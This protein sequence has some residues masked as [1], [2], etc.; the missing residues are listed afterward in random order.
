MRAL[1][2]ALGLVLACPVGVSAQVPVRTFGTA[3]RTGAATPVTVDAHGHA[4]V[5]IA[6]SGNTDAF[7]RLR[8][9]QAVTLFDSQF[10]YDLQPLAWEALTTNAGTVTHAP[11][12]ASAT[13]AVTATADDAA[14]LQTVQY[15]RYQP[16]KS[17]LVVMTFVLGAATANV[18]K[19]VGYFDA[20]NGLFLEQTATELRVCVRNATV[21]TCVAQAAWSEDRLDGT[22][23]SGVTLDPTRAQILFL[24]FQW[25]GVGRVRFGFDLDGV[26]VY[27]HQALHANAV[28]APYMATANLPLRYEIAKTG[29]AGTGTLSA[30]CSAVASE[31]GF[32]IERGYTFGTAATTGVTAATRRAVVSLRPA[33]TF[34]SLPNRSQV[35]V[36]NL[37][38]ALEGAGLVLVE[39]VYAP[40]FTG[41]PTWAAVDAASTVERSLHGDAA[42][43]ALTGGTVLATFLVSSAGVGGGVRGDQFKALATR[44][45]LALTAAGGQTRAYALVATALVG[46]PTIRAALNVR[47]LR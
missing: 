13:L 39:V 41:T 35:F 44:A 1:V 33:A 34:N 5:E 29:A 17:Q 20:S 8:T 6:D 32:E 3:P 19:R 10:Q 46:T 47:E 21:D 30:I 26:V 36:E 24:D 14:A 37:D 7:S 11:T 16:G 42:A 45:P 43:G 27:A 12:T 40:T 18:R 4:Q 23:P 15:H 9:S 38:V 25:L 31:G 22:G 2:A 28:T